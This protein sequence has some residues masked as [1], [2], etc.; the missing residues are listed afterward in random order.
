LT[1]AFA[2][3]SYPVRN[4]VWKSPSHLILEAKLNRIAA[5]RK[6]SRPSRAGAGCSYL[7]YDEWFRQEVGKDLASLDRG[8]SIS[9]KKCA[10]G[11]NGFLASE[12]SLV[13]RGRH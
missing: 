13:A 8:R 10:A 12:D 5:D 9:M 4:A 2:V 7:D 1:G 11:W 6:G 3:Q